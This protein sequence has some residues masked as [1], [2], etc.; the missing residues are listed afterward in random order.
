MGEDSTGAV[1]A[2]FPLCLSL[3]MYIV[4]CLIRIL[5]NTGLTLQVVLIS[6]IISNVSCVNDPQCAYH[7]TSAV[8]L[9]S[10]IYFDAASF[11]HE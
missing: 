8:W 6:A 9:S 2:L 1:E 3:R 7:H 4:V 10:H 11:I 5:I